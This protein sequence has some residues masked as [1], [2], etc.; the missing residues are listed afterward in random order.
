MRFIDVQYV[1][2]H[3]YVHCERNNPRYGKYCFAKFDWSK[4]ISHW[5]VQRLHIGLCS[6]A[7][8]FIA[9][10]AMIAFVATRHHPRNTHCL[11][12][13]MCDSWYLNRMSQAY[14]EVFQAFLNRS[15][16]PPINIMFISNDFFFHSMTACNTRCNIM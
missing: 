4:K 16:C 1:Y 2:F 11:N 14:K 10:V 8:M 5:R 12:I 7:K 9:I 15:V 6:H 13:I 3:V